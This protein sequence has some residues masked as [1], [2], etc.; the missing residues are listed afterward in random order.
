MMNTV[1]VIEFICLGCGLQGMA[2]LENKFECPKCGQRVIST[3][4]ESDASEV[5]V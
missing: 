4:K 5:V 1:D 2:H 3:I